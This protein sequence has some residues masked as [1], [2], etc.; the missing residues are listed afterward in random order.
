M[1]L[2]YILLAD[3]DPDHS[4]MFFSV[5]E[6][7]VAYARIAVRKDTQSVLAFLSDCGW[8][9]LPDMIV[10]NF[11]DEKNNVPDCLRELLMHDRYHPIPKVVLMADHNF[12]MR[13]QCE[14]LGIRQFLTR[15]ENVFDLEKN[16]RNIDAFLQEELQ[17]H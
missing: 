2:P 8:K 13:E 7:Q 10:F 1:K 4:D 9:D 14:M 11:S 15:A 16:M 17:L 6:K 3:D 5:F 12:D